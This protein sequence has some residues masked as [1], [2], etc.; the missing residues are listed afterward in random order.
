MFF[1]KRPGAAVLSALEMVQEAPAAGLPPAHV[2]VHAGSIVVQDGD[3]FG[4]N[5]NLAAWIA[6]HAG[7][8]HVLVTD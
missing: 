2:G 6:G 5:V 3:Y 4:R 8:G 1:F 7:A